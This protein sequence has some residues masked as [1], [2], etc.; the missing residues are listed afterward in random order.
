MTRK[1]YVSL[2]ADLV[3]NVRQNN[4]AGVQTIKVNNSYHLRRYA[5]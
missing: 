4:I 1:L 5:T 2:A 3:I